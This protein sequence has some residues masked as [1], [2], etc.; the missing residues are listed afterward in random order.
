MIKG[1]NNQIINKGRQK[2]LDE[3]ENRQYDKCLIQLLHDIEG[4][5]ADLNELNSYIVVNSQYYNA[6]SDYTD[7]QIADEIRRCIEL[8]ISTG[9]EDRLSW[10]LPTTNYDRCLGSDRKLQILNI[11]EDYG[12][13]YQSNATDRNNIFFLRMLYKY[14]ELT[15]DDIDLLYSA[16]CEINNQH[17]QFQYAV[18]FLYRVQSIPDIFIEDIQQN[19]EKSLLYL[20][21]KK[22]WKLDNE[23]MQFLQNQKIIA[24]WVAKGHMENLDSYFFYNVVEDEGTGNASRDFDQREFINMLDRM[25]GK[26]KA[27]KWIRSMYDIP[28][29]EIVINNKNKIN[30]EQYETIRHLFPETEVSLK[31]PL[32][33]LYIHI[34]NMYI[35]LNCF[36]FQYMIINKNE[37]IYGRGKLVGAKLTMCPDFSLLQQLSIAKTNTSKMVPLSCRT[38]YYLA[39]ECQPFKEFI[40]L[41][42]EYI[43][44]FYPI[45]KDLL[46]ELV[47]S[48]IEWILPLSLQEVLQYHSKKEL[49]T[50]KYKI[51]KDLK[52]NY[53]KR[54]FSL[55]YI[56]IKTYPYLDDRSREVLVNIRDESLMKD[57]SGQYYY[58][59]TY[60]DKIQKF[61]MRYYS[62][63]VKGLDME[64]DNW[65]IRDYIEMSFMLKKK[66][67]LCYRSFNK[68]DDA[69]D[70]LANELMQK[71]YRKS[72]LKIPKDSR[73]NDLQKM[74]PPEFEWIKS[75][76]RL[77]I[78]G[79]KQDHCVFS[80]C[81]K[82]TKDHCAI[83]SYTDNTGEYTEHWKGKPVHYTIEF[84]CSN[85]KAKN[86][87][88][89]IAQIQGYK[90]CVNT[91][92]M[93]D[94]I[95]SLL[96]EY[97]RE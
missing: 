63:V 53:N 66:I 83:Y 74:L 73:F 12:L 11:P 26:D 39:R 62:G 25:Q 19:K 97:K 88:Y 75:K 42:L 1:F 79:K 29:E 35:N 33:Q 90:N 76:Q 72:T 47:Q 52:V 50:R 59:K 70:R 28:K 6:L 41:Y 34:N 10:L 13:E 64:A 85:P 94:Y 3:A 91:T 48:D 21:L 8:C 55:S 24:D 68:I 58:A 77:F 86:K 7:K 31:I 27:V 67:S 92:K 45:A 84:R 54:S 69:H 65:I 15:K 80:Y 95:Q 71:K 23:T 30:K 14:E 38:I 81:D 43:S 93:K 2:I 46:K 22:H 51:A 5:I 87:T 4:T 16:Y 37:N 61:I 78:E 9:H 20:A 32:E 56:I 57:A 36:V 96:K 82:I 49:F 18:Y 60:K 44:D 89:H 17:K 40:T